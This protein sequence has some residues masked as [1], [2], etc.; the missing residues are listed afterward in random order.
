MFNLDKK[1][2]I[3]VSSLILK[4]LS[5]IDEV[6][7]T[8]IVGTFNNKRF[9]DIDTVV[10][11]KKLNRNVF[12]KCNKTC[13]NLINSVT[14]LKKKKLK[15]KINNTF[16]PLKFDDEKNLVIHLM[17]YDIDSHIKHV[18]NSPFTCLDWERSKTFKGLK[19]SDICSPISIQFSDFLKARRG[20]YDY[21]NDIKNNKISYRKYKWYGNNFILEKKEKK[22]NKRDKF[23][24]CYHILNNTLNN[25][26][27]FKYQKN[28]NSSLKS[29]IS[30]L[31]IIN[32]EIVNDYLLLR[33][34][35][36]KKKFVTKINLIDVTNKFIKSFIIFL[37]N[38]RNQAQML[39]FVRHEKTLLNN[40]SF[41]GVKRNPPI[42]KKKIKKN[43]EHFDVIIS[44]PLKR[45][46]Q[47]SKYFIFNRIITNKKLIEIN[48]GKMEGKKF[49][50]NDNEMKS[51]FLKMSNDINIKFP[52]GESYKEVLLRT[53][54]FLNKDIKKIKESRILIITHNVV[55]KQL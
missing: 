20:M 35:K 37:D 26:L 16:G 55:L 43:K 50:K 4:N 53:K 18:I 39:K 41:L 49:Y 22:L 44:S 47:T 8:T 10:I 27:K 52:E 17:I 12:F 3:K 54:L 14:E 21:L 31:E 48:Y 30:I 32:K 9:S 34:C 11:C 45:T 33:R 2:K 7:S 38:Y 15:I 19:L 40:G 46:L 5:E 1:L 42:I 23:E 36:Q 28:L 24:F 29:R 51:L 6:I 13:K 25:F